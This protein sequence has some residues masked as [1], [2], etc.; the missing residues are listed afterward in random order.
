ME[1]KPTEQKRQTPYTRTWYQGK[2]HSS[3]LYLSPWLA[4]PKPRRTQAGRGRLKRQTPHGNAQRVNP[5]CTTL[6]LRRFT[7]WKKANGQRWKGL[8]DIPPRPPGQ[9]QWEASGEDGQ[10]SIENPMVPK[11][12]IRK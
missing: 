11:A 4:C 12:V 2:S 9:S 6:G 5:A 3:K 10:N 8:R 1:S 7:A